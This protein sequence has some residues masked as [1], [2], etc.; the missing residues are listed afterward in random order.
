MNSTTLKERITKANEKVT[1][2]QNTIVKKTAQIE[3]KWSAL[4]SKYNW[5]RT[6]R[7]THFIE[8]KERGFSDDAAS[9]ISWTISDIESLE[10]DIERGG[11]EIEE[12]LK[13]IAKYETQLASELAKESTVAHKYPE[14]FKTLKTNLV[15]EWT[16][17]DLNRKAS[18]RAKYNELGY[19]EFMKQYKW[20]G[21]D[22]MRKTEEEIRRDNNRT[23]DALILNL[24]N[25]VNEKVGDPTDYDLYLESGNSIEGI[26]LN[27]TVVGTKGTAR[28]ES[29]LAGGYNI[30]RLHI[31]VLVK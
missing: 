20:A 11:K 18:L 10:E 30:Q 1:K 19:K 15:E 23:A 25:R 28:V 14:E 29:I 22:F 24:W 13:T 3:K 5:D 6:D 12:T 21:Y 4:E 9:E 27:G 31:R 17:Y 7:T 2:K 8:L 26:A 16:R